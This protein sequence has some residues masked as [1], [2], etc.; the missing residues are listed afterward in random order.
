[1]THLS[2]GCL[3][4]FSVKMC[5][6]LANYQQERKYKCLELMLKNLSLF[7]SVNRLTLFSRKSYGWFGGCAPLCWTPSAKNLPL[8]STELLSLYYIRLI[9]RKTHI[10]VCW[11]VHFFLDRTRIWKISSS[12]VNRAYNSHTL[13]CIYKLRITAFISIERILI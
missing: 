7:G 3:R 10:F 9:K 6:Y 5:E 13:F 4:G 11:Y 2:W 8:R 12:S 1:M